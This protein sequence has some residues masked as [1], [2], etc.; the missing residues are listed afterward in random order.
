MRQGSACVF[1][2]LFT[3]QLLA[4]MASHR[5]TKI[6]SPLSNDTVNE[7]EQQMENAVVGVNLASTKPPTDYTGEMPISWLLP[8]DEIFD[9]VVAKA[10]RWRCQSTVDGI[11]KKIADLEEYF[12]GLDPADVSAIP[13][14]IECVSAAGHLNCF[15]EEASRASQDLAVDKL[16]QIISLARWDYDV[17]PIMHLL[18]QVELPLTMVSEL[19]EQAAVVSGL[20]NPAVAEME[21]AVFNLLDG[22][23][24]IQAKHLP[25]LGPLVAG[26]VRS[27]RLIQQL[28]LSF[29]DEYRSQLE[30]LVRCVLRGLRPSGQL[31][32][33]PEHARPIQR[34]FIEELLTM[35]QDAMDHSIAE[36]CLPYSTV[37][38]SLEEVPE[39]SAVSEWG[40]LAMLQ[41][42]WKRKSSRVAVRFHQREFWIEL[43][44]KQRLLTGD[45]TPTVVAGDSRLKPV[46]EIEVTCWQTDENIDYLEMELEFEQQF[47]LERQIV[48]GRDDDFLLIADSIH[49]NRQSGSPDEIKYQLTIPL[50]PGTKAIEETDTREIY[51]HNQKIQSLVMPFTLPEWKQDW[52]AG[53]FELANQQLQFQQQRTGRNLY[54]G[55]C[56]DLKPKRSLRP[57]T[58]R[59]L[60]VAENLEIVGDDVAVAFRIQVGGKQWVLYRTMAEPRNRTFLGENFADDFYLGRFHRD[61]DVESLVE[62]E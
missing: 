42:E 8:R 15:Y 29:N 50:A 18:L 48:L 45:L 46:D 12:A 21:S 36:T 62:I 60:T 57:R 26:W 59:K 25:S 2:Y 39:E 40:C 47:T 20:A 24:L 61:G 14:A 32:G 16:S 17:D 43:C 58:W 55:L 10:D 13:S 37:R 34:E 7:S 56:F 38:I 52:Q 53:S 28:G 51:L 23:G 6:Q 19:R 11:H 1:W 31:M 22:D 41:T 9:K 27:W 3:G 35:S 44:R 33:A 54:A 49:D 4:K 5:L 30:W